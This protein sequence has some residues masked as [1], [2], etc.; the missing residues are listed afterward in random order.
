MN[1]LDG[2]QNFLVL[3]AGLSGLSAAALLLSKGKNVTL[4]DD[5]PL[6]ALVHFEKSG[7]KS[8]PHLSLVFAEE[9][10]NISSFDIIIPSPG[11]PPEHELMRALQIQQKLFLSD[12][13]LGLAFLDSKCIVIGITGSNG[14][15]STTVMLEE[16]LKAAGKKVI[17]GANLGLPVCEIILKNQD[18]LEYLILELSSFQIE[19]MAYARLDLAIILN[20]SPNHLDRHPTYQDYFNAKL[21]ISRLLKPEGRLYINES[22]VKQEFFT[23]QPL[24]KPSFHLWSKNDAHELKN[25]GSAIFKGDH[26]QENRAAVLKASQFLGIDHKALI[27]GITNFSPLPHRCEFVCEKN[28]VRFV[29]DSKGTTVVAVEKA[30]SGFSSGVH[31]LLGG[32]SKG[33]SFAALA[34]KY[35][36]QLAGYYVFGQAQEKILKDLSGCPS[37]YAVNNLEEA[38][39]MALKKARPG[40]TILLSPGCSSFDQFRDFVERGECFRRLALSI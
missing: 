19:L 9:L 34:P 35:F 24:L 6:S 27:G 12:I 31:L 26:Y 37:C 33:E 5:R 22:V 1:F 38:F 16:V 2:K 21:A 32:I 18:N 40:D 23:L 20:I 11:F 36:P 25:L 14:K 30:L 7:L 8:G 13:D 17:A 15:S 29:N 10:S 3:G 28:G 39:F 4:Y